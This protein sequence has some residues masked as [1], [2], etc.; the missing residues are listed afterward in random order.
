[1]KKVKSIEIFRNKNLVNEKRPKIP[2]IPK[3]LLKSKEKERSKEK[4]FKKRSKKHHHKK[5][6]ENFK[7]FS[8]Q[9]LLKPKIFFNY[10]SPP[11]KPESPVKKFSPASRLRG[12]LKSPTSYR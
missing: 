4:F 2:S 10:E 8:S 11:K 6:E 9:K 7:E 12:S 5:E 3:F 1:M